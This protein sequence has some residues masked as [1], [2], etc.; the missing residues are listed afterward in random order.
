MFDVYCVSQDSV[1]WANLWSSFWTVWN[2]VVVLQ[3][4]RFWM[5][6]HDCSFSYIVLG[7]YLRFCRW[8]K[9]KSKE[10]IQLIISF[11]LLFSFIKKYISQS[12]NLSWYV[13]YVF[14]FSSHSWLSQAFSFEPIIFFSQD[15]KY[16]CI[17]IGLWWLYLSFRGIYELLLCQFC[18][19]SFYLRDIGA[20]G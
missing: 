4:I 19:C 20:C 2:R 10:T 11:F 6:L 3:C 7:F 5:S 9:K 15:V 12:S 1:S 17:S 18:V 13:I 16:F 8:K 14:F